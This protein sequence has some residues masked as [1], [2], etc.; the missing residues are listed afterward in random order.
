[1][2]LQFHNIKPAKGAR[3]KKRILGRGNASGRGNYSGRGGKGQRARSGGKSGLKMKGFKFLLQSTPKLRGAHN[4]I[5]HK[6]VGEVSL[7]DLERKYALGEVV[8]VASLREKS[9]IKKQISKVKILASG[10]LTKKLVIEGVA[11]TKK[12]AEAIKKAGGE[13]K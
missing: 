10:E 12:A 3:K 7:A 5:I 2:I 11:C 9:L 6:K 8:N 4:I 1:M 13:V